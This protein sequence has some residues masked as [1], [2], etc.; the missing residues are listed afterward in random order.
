MQDDENI[1]HLWLFFV[2]VDACLCQNKETLLPIQ[3]YMTY[4]NN[5]NKICLF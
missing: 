1:E 5:N 3:Y 4:N 2:V